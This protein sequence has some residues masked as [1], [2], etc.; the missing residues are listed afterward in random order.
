MTGSH[1][2][3]W[4]QKGGG[5]KGFGEGLRAVERAQNALRATDEQIS[6]RYC[7]LSIVDTTR[8]REDACNARNA[9][10]CIPGMRACRIIYRRMEY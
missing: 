2:G 10:L 6:P 9:C 7:S 5:G 8:A 3:Q 4:T 1:W